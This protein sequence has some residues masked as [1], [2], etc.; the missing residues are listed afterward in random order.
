M[1]KNFKIFISGF[2]LACVLSFGFSGFASEVLQTIKVQLNSVNLKVNGQTIQADNIL[3]NGTTYIPLRA[4]ANALGKNV[5]WDGNTN[6]ASIND[7]GYVEPVSEKV[8]DKPS[9][10]TSQ[11]IT[12]SPIVFDELM[13][14]NG[15]MYSTRIEKNIIGTPELKLVAKNTSDKDI[16]SFEFKCSFVDSFDK[17]VYKTGT[18]TT[19]FEGVVQD[20]NLKNKNTPKVYM[21]DTKKKIYKMYDA[22]EFTFNLVLYNLAYDIKSSGKEGVSDITVTKVKFTDGTIWELK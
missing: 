2:L 18:K 16:D 8:E 7:V 19:T 11:N 22:N 20:A 10:I 17:S 13:F 12:E 5:G 6:T 3:Y 15:E 14:N 21:D 9:Q 4:T 1:S